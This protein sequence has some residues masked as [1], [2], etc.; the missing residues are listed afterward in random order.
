MNEGKVRRLLDTSVTVKAVITQNGPD[1]TR[2]VDGRGIGSIQ[3][4]LA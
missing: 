2:E 1:L 3:I 4:R